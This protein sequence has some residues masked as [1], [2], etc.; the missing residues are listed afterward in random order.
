MAHP[1]I[2]SF[3]FIKQALCCRFVFLELF[4]IQLLNKYL[5][6]TGSVSVPGLGTFTIVHHPPVYH[7]VAQGFAAPFDSI[8]YHPADRDVD[9]AFIRYLSETEQI[10]NKTAKEHLEKM[11]LEVKAELHLQGTCRLGSIGV[12]KKEQHGVPEFESEFFFKEIPELF[13]PKQIRKTDVHTITVGDQEKSNFEMESFYKQEPK[14]QKASW[15]I[16][17]LVAGILTIAYLGYYYY[18]HKNFL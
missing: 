8:E 2:F 9:E 17:A 5:S 10:S 14:I 7:T 15:W 13:A 18:V 12:I 3:F 1:Y 6:Q 4:M 11:V 16:A